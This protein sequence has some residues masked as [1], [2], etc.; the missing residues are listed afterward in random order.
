M[1]EDPLDII[2]TS[3]K[4]LADTQQILAETQRHLAQTQRG[5]A[6]VQGIALGLL[7][8]CLLGIGIL[9]WHA[10]ALRAESAVQTEA[11]LELVRRG[12]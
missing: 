6:W 11:L 8:L 4:T 3:Y 10:F 1:A 7:G 12:P 9:V 2:A 5:L